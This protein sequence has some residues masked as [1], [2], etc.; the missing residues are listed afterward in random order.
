[1]GKILSNIV[2]QPLQKCP[3]MDSCP[4]DTLET[5]VKCS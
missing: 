1:M 3:F 2:V 4:N 5:T